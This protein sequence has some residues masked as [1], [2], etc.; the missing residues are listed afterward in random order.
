MLT[1]VNLWMLIQIRLKMK[2]ESP[3]KLKPFKEAFVNS[4][5]FVF[6]LQ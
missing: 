3:L 5:N 2:C 4:M 6:S 1:L